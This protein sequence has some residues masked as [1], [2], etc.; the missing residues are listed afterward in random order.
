VGIHITNDFFH[1]DKLGGIV[2]ASGIGKDA[3]GKQRHE[4]TGEGSNFTDAEWLELRELAG[5]WYDCFQAGDHGTALDLRDAFHRLL[6]ANGRSRW[7]LAVADLDAGLHGH[8]QSALQRYLLQ[9]AAY[10]KHD[11]MPLPAPLEL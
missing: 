3:N 2:G 8:E 5:A 11:S 4:S 10:H 1:R 9:F 7:W 6:Q